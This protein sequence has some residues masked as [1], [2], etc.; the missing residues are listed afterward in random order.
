M[1]VLFEDAEDLGQCIDLGAR[2][3]D[4]FIGKV[5]RPDQVL[6]AEV[7]FSLGLADSKTGEL[8]PMPLIGALDTADPADNGTFGLRWRQSQRTCGVKVRTADEGIAATCFRAWGDMAREAG[9]AMR[10]FG[11]RSRHADY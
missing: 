6:G 10:R 7:P 3:I 2:M 8:F 11:Y 5:P 1:P 9:R 4:T